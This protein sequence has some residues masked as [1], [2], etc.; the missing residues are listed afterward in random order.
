MSSSFT[1]PAYLLGLVVALAT[2]PGPPAQAQQPDTAARHPAPKP[3]FVPKYFPVYLLDGRLILGDTGLRA[4]GPQTIQ[5][6]EI[7]KGGLTTPARWRSLG[8]HGIVV[9]TLKKTARL[10]APASKS[11][12][13]I[14]REL[15]LPATAQFELDGLPLQDPRLRIASAD[16]EALE[17]KNAPGAAPVINVRLV[18]LPPP[19]RPPGTILIQGLTRGQ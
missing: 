12:A 14:R 1:R 8:P 2:L 18:R 10:D 7:H 9:V 3:V 4:I 17:V 16:I 19:P 5:R 6:L 15:K 13:Q 11:Q